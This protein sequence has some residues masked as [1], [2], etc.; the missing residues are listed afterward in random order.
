MASGLESKYAIEVEGC[1]CRYLAF[2]ADGYTRVTYK[3]MLDHCNVT[4][5]NGHPS[6][7][8]NIVSEPNVTTLRCT[9]DVEDWNAVVAE[10]LAQQASNRRNFQ[11][12]AKPKNEASP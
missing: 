5:R 2:E 7:P 9:E 10:A 8:A 3:E 12:F 1:I 6:L 11:D 4:I